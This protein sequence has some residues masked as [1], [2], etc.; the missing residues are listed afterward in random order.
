MITAVI[1]AVVAVAGRA[2]SGAK[3]LYIANFKNYLLKWNASL[4]FRLF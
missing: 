1:A 4:C 3:P 2:D